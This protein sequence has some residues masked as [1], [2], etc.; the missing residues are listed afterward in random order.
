MPLPPASEARVVDLS[1]KVVLVTGATGGLGQE[2]ARACAASGATVV[3]HGRV[4]RKLEALYDEIKATSAPEPVILPLDYLR[5]GAPEFHAAAS[6]L[7]RDLGQ[8]D[9][10]V[11]TAT[12]LGSL[13]PIEH[14][15]FDRWLE[16][17]RVNVAAPMAL[18]RAMLPAMSGSPHASVVFTVNERGIAPRAYW[19]AFGASHAAIQALAATLADEW[20]HR[21]ELRV[22]AIVPGPLRSPFRT[23]T[24][25]GEDK[26][27]LP[28]PVDLVPL[29]LHLISG[30]SKAESGVRIDAHA[31]LSGCPAT[32]SLTQ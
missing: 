6:A 28:A 18:T 1:N 30:Q 2:I 7:Q 26:G 32:S 17:L 23:Q 29:Y 31:W 12:L 8:L 4:V 10:L 20:E 16:V 21:G 13:G 24:H 14:Q 9:G 15:S 27:P 25:P 22:N 19:G 5:A 11:H 3:L